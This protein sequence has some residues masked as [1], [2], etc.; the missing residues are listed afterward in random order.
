M[1]NGRPRGRRHLVDCPGPARD[2]ANIVVAGDVDMEL[3]R[4]PLYE[5]ELTVRVARSHGP[6]CHERAYEE[7]AVDYLIGHVRWVEGR[8]MEAVID[9]IASGRLKVDDLVTHRFDFSRAKVA[10]EWLGVQGAHYPGIQLEYPPKRPIYRPK[11]APLSVMSGPRDRNI[12]LI[13]AGDFARGVLVPAIAESGFGIIRAVASAGGISAQKPAHQIGARA[14]T[15]GEIRT[16][17]SIDTVLIATSHDTHAELT[18]KALEAAK[19]VECEKPL[20][21]TEE[22]LDR[23]EKVWRSSGRRLQVGFNRRYSEALVRAAAHFG[24]GGEP[25]VITYRVNAGSLASGHWYNDRRTGGRL[26]GEV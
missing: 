5:K 12:G 10:Y 2:R 23:V 24:S 8:N 17:N 14:V 19:H 18:I 26:I 1:V 6:G 16:D 3:E 25:V 11:S 7:W 13:G 9:L 21:V 20:A 15:T 4:T 22:E